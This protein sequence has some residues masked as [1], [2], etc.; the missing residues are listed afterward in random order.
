MLFSVYTFMFMIP[1]RVD[2]QIYHCQGFEPW[3]NFGFCILLK[4]NNK[5]VNEKI[6]GLLEL[7]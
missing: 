1:Q 2:L 3:A 4:D 6:N 7:K 5:E